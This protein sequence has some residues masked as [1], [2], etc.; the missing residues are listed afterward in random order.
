MPATKL[1]GRWGREASEVASEKV[2]NGGEE[3]A[4]DP[5]EEE[6]VV[7]AADDDADD[8][9]NAAEVDKDVEDSIVRL[10]SPK[11]EG[12]GPALALSTTVTI[13]ETIDAAPVVDAATAAG[14]PTP[15]T[16]LTPV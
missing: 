14:A 8:A 9:D 1:T 13:G 4:D 5:V 7:D 16:P 11:A 12:S 15:P 10:Y 2:V 3:P 6:E